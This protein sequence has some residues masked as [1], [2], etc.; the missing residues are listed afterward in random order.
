MYV[1]VQRLS[2]DP[3]R[4]RAIMRFTNERLIPRIRH[5]PGFRRYTVAGDLVSGH[6]LT[7]TEWDNLEQAQDQLAAF[8]LDQ[9]TAD[10]GINLDDVYVYE[11]LA[12]T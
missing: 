3:A 5:L 8:G 9:E 6:A 7:I 10:L 4:A 11:V 2:L 1:R 12:Q